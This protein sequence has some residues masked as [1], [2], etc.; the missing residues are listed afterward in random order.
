MKANKAIDIVGVGACTAVGLTASMSAASVRAGIACLREH[1]YLIDQYG[2]SMVVAMAS[3]LPVDLDERDRLGELALPAAL[4]AL[5]PLSR[6]AENL[7]RLPLVL[8]LP[9]ERPGLPANLAGEIASR[10]G[11]RIDEPHRFSEVETISYGH[12][13][14]LMAIEEGCRK[15]RSGST[16]FCLIGGVDS[17]MT[18]TTLEWLDY[19]GHLRSE[20]NKW[21]FTPGEAAGFCLLASAQVVER[22]SLHV[23]GSVLEAVTARER[24]LIHTDTVC[25][26]EG[27]TS[28]FKQ[29]LQ[30]ITGADQNP[31]A[32]IDQTL[33]DM[34]GERYRADEYGFTM[35]R[36]SEYFVDA[37]D[38]LTP[39]DCWGDVG[40]A[41]GPLFVTLAVAS[42][43]RGYAKGPF[44]LVW[45]SSEGGERSAALLQVSR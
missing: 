20:T 5:T 6:L 15:I 41:S 9:S 35:A 39:A 38:F 28:A 21:G 19:Q 25:T 11:E 3:Y 33:C 16:D 36:V 4:E 31:T 37:T 24:N 14:G 10:F 44:T 32:K 30:V 12:S 18:P 42:G 45:T 27:L 29:V 7:P 40:A 13:A 26:G 8:G 1:P 23:L 22:Y 2:E 17:Y 34:N 43:L